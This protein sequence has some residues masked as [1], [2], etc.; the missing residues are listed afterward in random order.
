MTV[1]RPMRMYL[2][3]LGV[4]HV[5]LALS[6]WFD[7]RLFSSPAYDWATPTI[8][9]EIAA[10][11]ASWAVVALLLVYWRTRTLLACYLALGVSSVLM[12]AFASSVLLW[13]LDP[14][15]ATNSLVAVVLWLTPSAANLSVLWSAASGQL[16]TEE[17]DRARRMAGV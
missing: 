3:W 2:T 16:Q 6:L 9:H 1:L 17:V 7:D 8:V 4:L 14:H 13:N 15:T 11:F 12:G 5:V 10:E